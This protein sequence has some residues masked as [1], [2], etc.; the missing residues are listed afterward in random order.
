MNVFRKTGKTK[1]VVRQPRRKVLVAGS[2]GLKPYPRRPRRP[3]GLVEDKQLINTQT[4]G[5]QLKLCVQRR[6]GGIGDVLMTTPS[7]R[8]LKEYFPECHLTYATDPNYYSGELVQILEGNP[9]IDE[10]AD[11]K[12]VTADKFHFFVDITS[13]CPQREKK[14][15]PPVN[16]I[17]MFSEHIG[18]RL[19]D[20][21]PIY[22]VTKEEKKWCSSIYRKWFGSGDYKVVVIHTASVDSRR[23]WPVENY[24][25]LIAEMTGKRADLRFVIFDQ[26][27]K[28]L[29]W[30][31]KNCVNASDYGI[32]Q[33]AAL[34]WGCDVFVGPDSGPMH[35]AGALSKSMVTLFGSTD[36]AARI[37]H[38]DNAVSVT[39]HQRCA[40]CWYDHCDNDLACMKDIS[41][42]DVVEALS[43]K[44]DNSAPVSLRS[45]QRSVIFNL[46]VSC[47]TETAHMAHSIAQSLESA[48]I[49]SAINKTPRASNDIVVDVI[50]LSSNKKN[51]LPPIP[52]AAANFCFATS[53]DGHMSQNDT[54]RL[55]KGYSE[56]LTLTRSLSLPLHKAGLPTKTSSVKP[57]ANTASWQPTDPKTFVSIAEYIVPENLRDIDS[58]LGSLG[59]HLKLHCPNYYPIKGF[60][61]IS[62]RPLD[63]ISSI[64][65]ILSSAWAYLDLNG[66]GIGWYAFSAVARGIPVVMGAYP[67]ADWIGP[68]LV[69]RV[70]LG[71]KRILLDQKT[72]DVLCHY[73]T[74]VEDQLT[75]A[76]S[77]VVNLYDALVLN[78]TLPDS[79]VRESTT[80]SVPRLLN[81]LARGIQL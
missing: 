75:D 9:Y 80:S 56:V 71:D 23:T 36:P 39:A 47:D 8:A 22:E 55:A 4:S 21:L 37:N 28:K 10:I 58:V 13:V 32:R 59:C 17:D 60:K 19:A 63:D 49:K 72:G 1:A 52:D 26:N 66:Y 45:R 41:I 6:L 67:Q 27:R 34:I 15:N 42:G 51:H 31:L 16:R 5:E 7:V 74:F 43:D 2:D 48:G 65:T 29:T 61:N 33:K 62:V 70:P 44:L 12:R 40:P 57:P 81:I 20:R 77:S 25:N 24:V 50:R 53:L 38:Y 14:E 64:N 46:D 30:D 79:L 18:I 78:R 69:Y 35:L 73:H 11:F 3:V 68:D 54:Y 76:I